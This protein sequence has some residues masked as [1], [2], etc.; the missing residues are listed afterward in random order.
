MSN[1]EWI[2]ARDELVNSILNLGFPEELGDEIAKNLGSPKAMQRMNAY[3][4]YVKPDKVDLVV[5]EMLAIKSEIEAWREKKA[6]QEAN[7]KYNEYLNHKI[8]EL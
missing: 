3:L 6:S 7:E 8:M 1:T 2:S 5:D 4:H